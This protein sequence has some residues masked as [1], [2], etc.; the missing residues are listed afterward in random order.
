MESDVRKEIAPNCGECRHVLT[1][2]LDLDIR[3]ERSCQ[4]KVLTD[5]STPVEHGDSLSGVRG[6]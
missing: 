2:V 5:S 1:V 3:E 4:R 6:T